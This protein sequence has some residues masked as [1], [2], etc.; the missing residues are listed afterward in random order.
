MPSDTPFSRSALPEPLDFAEF[1]ALSQGD[2]TCRFFD[3]SNRF[4]HRFALA[5]APV[6]EPGTLLSMAGGLAALGFWKTGR[7]PRSRGTWNRL[8][9]ARLSADVRS[10]GSLHTLQSSESNALDP[11]VRCGHSKKIS[12]ADRLWPCHRRFGRSDT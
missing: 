10:A 3:A 2:F 7:Q 12:H 1:T 8:D 11:V 6:P 5:A 9:L 4:R